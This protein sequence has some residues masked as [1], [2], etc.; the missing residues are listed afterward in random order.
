M[1]AEKLIGALDHPLRRA[2]LNQLKLGDLRVQELA[3]LV[4]APMNLVS[5]HLKKLREAGL[6]RERRSIADGRD[7][8]YS[9][10]LRALQDQYLSLGTQLHPSIAIDRACLPEVDV[11]TAV[12]L[13]VL[14]L[15]THNSARSQMAE[16]ILKAKSGATFEVAS[17][18]THP[19]EV[20]PLAIETLHKRAYP[21]SSLRS[22]SLEQF[23]DQPFDYV[24]TVCDRAREECPVFA[25]T[26]HALHWSLPDPSEVQGPIQNRRKAFE[27]TAQ[28]LEKR[29]GSLLIAINSEE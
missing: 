24:I 21:A 25:E 3:E 8:Y 6:V 4:G 10:D 2:L 18:G 22:K 17:A 12:G 27:E 20:H 15:C 28:E 23:T 5:Y 7:Q 13:R 29:I 26:K 19:S 11:P 1:V 16:A 14:F 9:L